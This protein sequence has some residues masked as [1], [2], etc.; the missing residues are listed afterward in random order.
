MLSSSRWQGI[1]R[2]PLKQRRRNTVDF[3]EQD[4]SLVHDPD[5]I[6]QHTF[7]VDAIVYIWRAMILM[8][9]VI[10]FQQRTLSNSSPQPVFKRRVILVVEP[11]EVRFSDS[12]CFLPDAQLIKVANVHVYELFALE[13]INQSLNVRYVEVAIWVHTIAFSVTFQC[14]LV[15]PN[16]VELKLTPDV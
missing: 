14:Q 3:V 2:Y 12:V 10:A 13:L 16:T 5:A 9:R 8:R 1:V 15:Q 6:W 11:V 4:Y 7:Q